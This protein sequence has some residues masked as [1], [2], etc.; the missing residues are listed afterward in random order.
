MGNAET[1]LPGDSPPESPSES[2]KS[3]NSPTKSRKLRNPTEEVVDILRNNRD[4]FGNKIV[5][6]YQQMLQKDPRIQEI[7][8]E[9]H[10]NAVANPSSSNVS[11]S[12]SKDRSTP[13]IITYDAEFMKRY[14]D[15][16]TIMRIIFEEKKKC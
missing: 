9:G 10:P 11:Q 13:E 1:S 4:K 5:K 2:Q 14:D 8:L 15:V 7:Y 16:D 12:S 3:P 6:D